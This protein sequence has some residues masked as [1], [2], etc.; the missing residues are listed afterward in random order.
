MRTEEEKFVLEWYSDWG[1]GKGE[2]KR[3]M[4]RGRICARVVFRLGKREKWE[5]ERGIMFDRVVFRLGKG[6]GERK[7]KG[8]EEIFVLEWYSD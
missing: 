2:R 4:G 1:K 8:E 7:R 6:K 3:K 5:R